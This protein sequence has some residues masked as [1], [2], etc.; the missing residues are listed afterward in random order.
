MELK[1]LT[2]LLSDNFNSVP[3]ISALELLSPFLGLLACSKV[4]SPIVNSVLD[5][6]SAIITYDIIKPDID[7]LP[8][9][10]NR[11]VESVSRCKFDA[12]DKTEDERVL[13]KIVKVFISLYIVFINIIFWF[14][15]KL[16]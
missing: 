3:S 16:S 8:A 11:T 10:L 6:L 15:W 13:M 4:N 2:A 7:D 1:K 14:N 5:A 12:T 9:A